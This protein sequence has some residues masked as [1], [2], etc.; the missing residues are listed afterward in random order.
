MKAEKSF[1]Q[2][3]EKEKEAR[4][5]LIM[6]A[7]V[8]MFASETFDKVNMRD[9]AKA[10]GLSPGSI[11]TYFP[12]QETLFV[13]TSLRGARMLGDMFDEI[14][15]SGELSVEKT[16]LAYIDTIMAHFEYLRMS[17]HCILYGKFKSQ[18]SLNR[19]IETYRS[20]FDR[21]ERILRDHV[22]EGD[23][24]LY[25]HLLFASLNGIL[26]SF[27]RYPGRRRDEVVA[28]MHDL[29][30]ALSRLLAGARLLASPKT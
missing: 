8:R 13:E 28:H 21:L 14:I 18:D 1:T 7:A 12:D 10:V 16:A 9:I 24:R 19:V 25:T 3:R 2:L 20:L 23:A 27:G 5:N 17:Q 11:Y 22:P 29:T 4:R 15:E 6:D 26:L 30:R